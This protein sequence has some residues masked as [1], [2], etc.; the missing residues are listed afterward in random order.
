MGAKRAILTAAVLG[1]VAVLC[2]VL[3]VV[4]PRQDSP[5]RVDVIVV[6]GGPVAESIDYGLQLAESGVADNVLI[7]TPPGAGGVRGKAACSQARDV[8]VVCFTPRNAT[9]EGEAQSAGW[10]AEKEGWGSMLVVTA[11]FHV[12]RSRFI[13]DRCSTHQVLVKATETDIPLLQWAGQLIYQP[14]AFLKAALITKC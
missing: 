10:R 2:A 1:I 4:F 5:S 9:T 13:F 6:L 11:K 3:V 8:N 12:A 14:V 7:S